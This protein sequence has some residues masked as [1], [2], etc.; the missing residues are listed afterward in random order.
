MSFVMDY[1]VVVVKV[2][3]GKA[4]A[5]KTVSRLPPG[6]ESTTKWRGYR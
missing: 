4:L 1:V 5:I 6:V 3:P 2:S